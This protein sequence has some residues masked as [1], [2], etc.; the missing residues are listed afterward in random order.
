MKTLI[1]A[2][3]FTALLIGGTA[4]QS[5]TVAP[6]LS[7]TERAEVQRLVPE[8][9]LHRL[10]DSQARALSD[11][12]ARSDQMSRQDARSAALDIIAEQPW[13]LPSRAGAR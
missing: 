10:T 3:S 5:M 6:D 9:S 1:T 4:A 13:L 8:A 2:L 7:A 11:V 12:V